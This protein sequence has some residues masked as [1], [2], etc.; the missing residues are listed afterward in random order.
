M[1]TPLG[2]MDSDTEERWERLG[3]LGDANT[4]GIW[5]EGDL[6]EA[7]S[8]ASEDDWEMLGDPTSRPESPPSRHAVTQNISDMVQQARLEAESQRQRA[9]E[10]EQLLKEREDE[11]HQKQKRVNMLEQEVE[12]LPL[13]RPL[14][15]QRVRVWVVLRLHQTRSRGRCLA[16]TLI[17]RK[18]CAAAR[19]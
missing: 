11:L 6:D 18:G 12:L 16:R 2:S 17:T 3:D 4:A 15:R 8:A 19:P 9:D 13:R 14:P 7:A 10:M 5:V 1:A